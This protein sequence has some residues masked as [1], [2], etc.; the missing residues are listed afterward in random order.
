LINCLNE[1]EESV[2]FL[3]DGVPV[4]GEQLKRDLLINHTF[5]PAHMNRQR[6]ASVGS[7]GIQ[8]LQQGKVETAAN[9]QPDYLRV[10]QAEREREK[11]NDK[12]S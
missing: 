7:L 9:H 6:A 10:S 11:Q 5:A 2:V 8:Y 3:G 1:R 12:S 4:Y